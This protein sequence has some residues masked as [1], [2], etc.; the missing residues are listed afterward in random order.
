MP[1]VHMLDTSYLA[2]HKPEGPEPPKPDVFQ[3]SISVHTKDRIYDTTNISVWSL[4][5]G[6]E[7]ALCKSFWPQ[8]FPVLPAF[9]S[10]PEAVGLVG[11]S[12]II[13]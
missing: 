5:V 4:Q 1:P 6:G 7:T 10:P 13:I 8:D 11:R 9:K 2:L 12:Q 3:R